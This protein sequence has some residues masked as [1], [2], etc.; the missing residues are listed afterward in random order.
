MWGLLVVVI[1]GIQLNEKNQPG[2]MPYPVRLT[3]P[4]A[5]CEAPSPRPGTGIRGTAR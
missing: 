4:E 2:D 3:T 5:P 1:V